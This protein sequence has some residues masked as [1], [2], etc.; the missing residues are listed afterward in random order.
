M[1]INPIQN[2]KII[3]LPHASGQLNA[4]GQNA[5]NVVG[6]WGV[7]GI[8]DLSATLTAGPQCFAAICGQNPG[9]NAGYFLGNITTA[10][11]KVTINATDQS[12]LAV[13]GPDAGVGAG[14]VLQSDGGTGWELLA[15]G[16]TSAQG[17]GQLNIRNLS[18]GLDVLTI[19]PD[20]NVKIAK[21]IILT[22]ADFAEDFDVSAEGVEP[23]TVMVLNEEGKLQESRDSYDPKVAGVISGGGSY[24]PAIIADRGRA[25]A[26]RLP[27]ALVGKVYCKADA[28]QSPI[29][30]GDLLTT[31][32]KPGHAMKAGDSKRAFGAVIGK[33]L[34]PLKAGQGLIPILVALQ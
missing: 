10:Q 9:G 24:K 14:M 8:G 25:S 26:Q 20:G 29:G 21:D 31:S 7:A 17:K 15:T 13:H 23:G 2:P 30:V 3:N 1:P 19:D 28:D 5:A 22:N 33:A 16:Q 12:G 18:T 34:Q 4:S 6:L 11:G 32:P 27:V